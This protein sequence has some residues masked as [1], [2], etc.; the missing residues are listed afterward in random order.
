M[1]HDKKIYGGTEPHILKSDTIW[2]H[3]EVSLLT[4]QRAVP[5]T[6]NGGFV[7]KKSKLTLQR[8]TRFSRH[9]HLAVH[10]T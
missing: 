1:Y 4:Q 5:R 9:V 7:R 3:W 8:P 10:C 2:I 6:Y